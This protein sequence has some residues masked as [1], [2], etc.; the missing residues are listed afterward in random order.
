M[1]EM[2]LVDDYP[3]LVESLAKTL[4]KSPLAISAVHTAFSVEEALDILNDN[5]IDIVVTDIQMPGQSGLELIAAIKRKWKSV[6]FVI[7]LWAEK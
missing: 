6:K 1:V 2:L 5:D 7:R 3:H 4:A